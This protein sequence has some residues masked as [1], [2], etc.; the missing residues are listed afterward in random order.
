M[1]EEGFLRGVSVDVDDY[2]MELALADND[3]EVHQLQ[4]HGRI[5]GATLVSIPAFEG[6]F[7]QIGWRCDLRSMRP[8]RWMTSMPRPRPT[9]RRLIRSGEGGLVASLWL[10]EGVG[11]AAPA[12][13]TDEQ[14]VKSCVIKG[15]GKS[16][17][18]LPIKEPNGDLNRAAVHSAA[19]RLNQT[20]ATPE[21][22]ATAKRAL[23]GAY[24]QLGEDVPDSLTAGVTSKPGLEDGPG[25]IT[26]PK[27]TKQCIH[28]YWTHGKGAAKI[29]WGVPGDFNRCRE[30]LGKYIKPEYLA[31]TC[32]Q[33][34]HDAIGIW[35]GQ[36]AGGRKGHH[37]SLDTDQTASLNDEN[38]LECADMDPAV[39]LVA[40]AD[41]VTHR[42]DFFENPNFVK[43]CPRS[44]YP[45]KGGCSA[46]SRTGR[47]ATSAS[48][49]GASPHRS[50]SSP[51][52]PTLRL[53]CTGSV[54]TEKGEI[55]DGHIT[56]CGGHAD[57]R[58]GYRPAHEHYDD[59]VLSGCRRGCGRGPVAYGSG[60][61][62]SYMPRSI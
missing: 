25:W 18:H 30:H 55:A 57:T 50:P 5:A 46:M 37:H 7:V 29:R 15:K 3:G 28:D 19:G 54:L 52:P 49:T 2:A 34:H 32:A 59:D 22:K 42:A 24:R 45:R 41:T 47:T 40:A 62:D 9:S 16:D 35:P 21:Q 13:F 48:R 58:L 12:R 20:D 11:R 39:N 61:R 1:I 33:W 53:L 44:S 60:C 26:D 14:Y 43:W 10:G 51:P 56:L 27:D 31:G 6:A 38:C 8:S 4:F 36:E 23:R 17:S